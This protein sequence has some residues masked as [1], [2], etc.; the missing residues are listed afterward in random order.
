[1]K[2]SRLRWIHLE[3]GRCG[4][5]YWY[6]P[7]VSLEDAAIHQNSQSKSI[8]HSVE[9]IDSDLSL[10]ALNEVQEIASQYLNSPQA[11]A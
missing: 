7:G 11:G 9:Y 8:L 4:H 6:P 10:E 1:M 3:T 2:Y 5:G